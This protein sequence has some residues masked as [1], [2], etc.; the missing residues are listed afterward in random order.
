MRTALPIGRGSKAPC[1]GQGVVG[2]GEETMPRDRSGR[3]SYW[4][5]SGSV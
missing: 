4:P 2:N 5:Q 1:P 3:H